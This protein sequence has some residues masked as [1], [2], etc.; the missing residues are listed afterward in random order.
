MTVENDDTYKR[1]SIKPTLENQ[2]KSFSSIGYMHSNKLRTIK[3]LIIHL[4]YLLIVNLT[5]E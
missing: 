2:S 3:R 5:W 1:G 4:G